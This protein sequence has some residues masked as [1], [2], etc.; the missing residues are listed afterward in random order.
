MGLASAHLKAL[1]EARLVAVRRSGKQMIYRLSGDD[2]AGPRV[3]MG[4]V[5]EEHLIELRV[6]LERI[7]ADPQQ[8][9]QLGR[10]ELIEQAR[11]GE[12]VVIDVRPEDE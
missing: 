3:K 2:V 10:A 6:A 4:E 7:S 5:A 11:R 12:I 1:R 8:L 9:A